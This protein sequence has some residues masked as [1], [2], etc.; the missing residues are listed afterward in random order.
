M[1]RIR[2][3][4]FVIISIKN[5]LFVSIIQKKVRFLGESGAKVKRK[6]MKMG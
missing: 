4:S 2:H 3:Q 1:I 5:E 6:D